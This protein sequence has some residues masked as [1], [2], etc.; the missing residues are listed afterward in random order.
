[1]RTFFDVCMG[2]CERRARKKRHV[3][4]RSRIRVAHTDW[5]WVRKR[6]LLRLCPCLCAWCKRNLWEWMKVLPRIGAASS[7]HPFAPVPPNAE[8]QRS[9][10]A[11]QA[12]CW[13]RVC[14]A[15][16]A[17]GRQKL[18]WRTTTSFAYTLREL[19]P[20]RIFTLDLS[21]SEKLSQGGCCLE[22]V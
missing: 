10:F 21:P 14:L 2:E 6:T 18:R 15:A 8:V 17:P 7:F 20:V 1:M 11:A 4:R 5:L 22:K 9:F 3:R 13:R 19:R 16:R 12:M